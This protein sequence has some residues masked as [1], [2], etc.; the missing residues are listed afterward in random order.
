VIIDLVYESW[1]FWAWHVSHHGRSASSAMVALPEALPSH[2]TPPDGAP[3]FHESPRKRCEAR[4]YG[5]TLV[6]MLTTNKI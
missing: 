6:Y 3:S 5:V 2:G 4:N 1:Y